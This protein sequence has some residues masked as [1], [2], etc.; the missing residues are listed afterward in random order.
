MNLF[1][2]FDSG[3]GEDERL[4]ER[5]FVVVSIVMKNHLMFLKYG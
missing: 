4:V 1:E 2:G 3:S 5:E